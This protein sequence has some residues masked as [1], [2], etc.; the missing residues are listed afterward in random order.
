M[1]ATREHQIIDALNTAGISTVTD[2]SY[3]GGGPSIRVS[4]LGRRLNPDIGRY[5]RLSRAQKQF[6]SAQDRQR[7]PGE[8]T[9]AHRK[10]WQSSARSPAALK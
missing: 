9:N 5:L 6:N 1:G 8:R 4:Q 2:T 3:Q 7:C 10:S